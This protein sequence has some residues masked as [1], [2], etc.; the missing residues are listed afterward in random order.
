MKKKII[1]TLFSLLLLSTL[2]V[3]IPSLDMDY[4]KALFARDGSLISAKL[5][6][7]EQWRFPIESEL[8]PTLKEAIIHF[9][10]EYF[11]SHPGVNPVS[12][13][14]AF[15]IN[16]KARHIKRGGSTITMQLMR[17]YRGND[18]RSYKQKLI[19][20]LG[21][22]KLELLYSKE[23]ILK[24]WASVAPFGG[25]TVG[26]STASWRY[27]ERPL[28]E[29]STAEYATLAVLPNAPS[30]IHLNKNRL[31]L[32]AKR[33]ALLEK[34]YKRNKI[35]SLDYKLSTQE[36]LPLQL[37]IVPQNAIHLLNY[38]SNTYP[39]KHLFHTTLST[40]HQ[41]VFND[42]IQA[43]SD[44]YQFDG[45]NNAAG[46]IMDVEANEVLAYIGNTSQNGEI[47]Y[48][49][50][51]Q[52]PRSYGSL[53]KPF[54]YAQAI[55][56]GY[57]SPHEL[58]KDIPT[59]IDG[60]TPKN[61]DR[62]FRGVVP[63]DQM[64][65]KS[66]NVPA[67]RVL[68]YVGLNTF[69]DLVTNDLNLTHITRDASHY[70]L[71]IILG[72]A[73]SSM[74]DLTNA[75]K[76]LVLNH[77]GDNHPFKQ[78]KVIKDADVNQSTFSFHPVA[79][80][81]TIE[82]MSSVNRPKEEQ[83]FIKMGGEKIAWK[84]GTSYGH[85]D[86]WSIGTNG[87][88]LVA[89]WVGNESGEGVYGLT[90]GKKAAP[91]LFKT[92]RRFAEG[93]SLHGYNHTSDIIEICQHSGMQKGKWCTQTTFADTPSISHQLRNCDRHQV[94]I[95]DVGSVDTVFTLTADEDYYH[96]QYSGISH[97]EEKKINKIGSPNLKIIYPQQDAIIVLPKKLDNDYSELK[98]E[99]SSL[100]ANSKLFWFLDNKFVASTKAPHQLSAPLKD[101]MHALVVNDQ[102]G[103]SEELQFE[104]L[105]R[106]D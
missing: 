1:F 69:H 80:S 29:L 24:M 7:D 102:H 33:D 96:H 14:K 61:F 25:N 9:E 90:G 100:I 103:N 48:V 39:D 17:M 46:I 16:F 44:I 91:I 92:L 85:R 41:S 67:V 77:K 83:H 58:I 30:S 12:I 40:T 22:L 31:K 68:N 10:D 34:L 106:T 82:A 28:E 97:A 73:E 79:A 18:K 59:S 32:K 104:I 6:T 27:F 35:D 38:L 51:V 23:D 36:D 94:V 87:K 63:M 75:Y 70:G 57:F 47:R 21:A 56:Q 53:L 2:A 54:L 15:Y 45:I 76:G 43:Q 101:G 74:W 55:D 95:D 78:V 65:S 26:A 19:E 42:I 5:A 62:Q 49:D 99:A 88:Y 50:C 93:N 64:V 4:S 66:L 81:Y 89:I 105:C 8:P 13:I 37:K 3:K 52:A 20:V 98:L 60:F 84:T 71:S 72:G 11:Y 86:A